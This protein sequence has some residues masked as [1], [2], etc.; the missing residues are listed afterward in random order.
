MT[1]TQVSI[2]QRLYAK[3]VEGPNGCWLFTASKT[4]AGYGKIGRGGKKLGWL[5]AH[6]VSY[7]IMVG[8]IP[9]G[10]TLD[11]LCRV[12]D[13]VNPDHLDPVPIGVNVARGTA[14]QARKAH[15]A[16][17]V[18]CL[19]AGHALVAGRNQRYCPTCKN[20][21]AVKAAAVRRV[22]KVAALAAG[23]VTVKHG[24]MSAYGE[25]RC[26]CEECRLASSTYLRASRLARKSN[27]V[28]RARVAADSAGSMSGAL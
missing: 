18:T 13:C 28:A 4:A 22:A 14:A 24:T 25:Y 17:Q 26:R 7:E 6:R 2:A 15:A 3:V 1:Y 12:P 21:N 9:V 19:R 11:H 10:L 23:T 20:E 8:P 5:Y 27:E 16:E